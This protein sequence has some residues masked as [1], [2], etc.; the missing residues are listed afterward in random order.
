MIQFDDNRIVTPRKIQKALNEG[1][2]EG[3]RRLAKFVCSDS[4]YP[5][6]VFEACENQRM[7]LYLGAGS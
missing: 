6:R 3:V 5:D 4:L 1:N 7:F 2:L